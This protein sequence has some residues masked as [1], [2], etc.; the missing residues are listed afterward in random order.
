MKQTSN[1]FMTDTSTVV[2]L[3]ANNSTEQNGTEQVTKLLHGAHGQ[4]D[5]L[6]RAT[7]STTLLLTFF[8]GGSQCKSKAS[9]HRTSNNV[10]CYEKLNYE[11]MPQDISNV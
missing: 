8:F 7:E 10:I 11:D 6:M 2:Q 3:N 5:A 9:N 4:W 1:Q